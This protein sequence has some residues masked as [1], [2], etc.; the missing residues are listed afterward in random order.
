MALQEAANR[1]RTRAALREE[2]RRL[3]A[4]E[5]DREEVRQVM[6]LMDELSPP[7]PE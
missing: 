2:A 5:A 1:R 6:E 7:W 4:D 3:G